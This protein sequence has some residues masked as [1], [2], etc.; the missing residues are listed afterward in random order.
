MISTSEFKK[1][2]Y[3]E[4]NQVPFLIL[5]FQHVKPGKGNAFVRTKI[6]NLVNNAVL[7]RTFKSGEKVGD[8]DLSER[9]MQFLYNDRD[10]YHF[11][12]LTEYEQIAFTE[13]TVG[14]KKFYLTENLELEVLY[15]KGRPISIDLPNF[16]QLKVSETDPG[17]KGDTSSGGGKPATMST[18]LNVTVPF[19]I[20][21]GELLKIDTR[22]NEYVEKIK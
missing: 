14:E 4:I 7:D 10:G 13:E 15:Y 17:G 11:M 18:G 1:G 21:T 2:M 8:P 3:I 6:K 20:K 12:D 19:H 5:E 22:T 9:K 16:V